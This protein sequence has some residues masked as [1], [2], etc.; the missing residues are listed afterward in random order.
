[1]SA[2]VS[3]RQVVRYS[4]PA[5]HGALNHAELEKLGL[6]PEGVL[7]FSSNINPYGAPAAVNEAIRDL[8][9]QRYPDG[10]SLHLRRALAE[11]LSLPVENIVAGNGTAELIWF[12]AFSFV[13]PGSKVLIFGPTFGEYAR[14]AELAGGLVSRVDG[15]AGDGFRLSPGAATDS[16]ATLQPEVVFICNPNNPTGAIIER[17]VIDRWPKGNPATLFVIDE[18]YLPFAAGYPSALSLRNDNV[19]VLRSLT[20]DYALAGLRLGYAAGPRSLVKPIAQV[21]PPW[22]VNVVAQAAGLAALRETTFLPTTMRDLQ[23]AKAKLVAGLESLDLCPLPSKTHFFV[24]DVGH[25]AGFRHKLLTGHHIQTRD[26]ASFGMPS[27][28][29][30]ATRRPEENS[31]LLEAV[32]DLLQ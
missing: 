9:W 4:L 6:D 27:Y 5:H 16:L 2:K 10:Q 31:R 29:R 13:R 8:P 26:C 23:V 32:A 15:Q 11:Q 17:E 24:M 14:C 28:I 21:Q 22:S 18:A 20:K 12:I 7:D 3:P 30:I 1:M 19:L 25:A